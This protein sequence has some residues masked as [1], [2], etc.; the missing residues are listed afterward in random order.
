M[1][2]TTPLTETAAGLWNSAQRA[3]LGNAVFQESGFKP[4]EQSLEG[5]P[6]PIHGPRADARLAAQDVQDLEHVVGEQERAQS[7]FRAVAHRDRAFDD[8]RVK[9]KSQS[10]LPS[11]QYLPNQYLVGIFG[12]ERRSVHAVGHSLAGATIRRGAPGRPMIGG[13]G[14]AGGRP[15][16]GPVRFL[17]HGGRCLVKRSVGWEDL[18]QRTTARPWPKKGPRRETEGRDDPYHVFGLYATRSPR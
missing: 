3:L 2:R 12:L 11:F 17:G 6:G 18:I 4:N 14:E 9:L 16:T 15:A 5:Y 13:A 7:A 8:G 10:D 1:P